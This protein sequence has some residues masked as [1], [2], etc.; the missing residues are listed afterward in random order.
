MAAPPGG[1]RDEGRPRGRGHHP[2]HRREGAAVPRRP[3]LPGAGR[4]RRASTAP[5]RA[6]RCRCA[7]WPRSGRSTSCWRSAC[8]RAA[9]APTAWR[10]GRRVYELCRVRLFSVGPPGARYQDV[11]LDLR[12]V[13]DAGAAAARGRPT[14]SPPDDLERRAAPAGTGVGAVPGERRRQ[15]GAAQAGVLGAAAGPPP[16]RGHDEHRRA[17]E[18]RARRG[19]RARRVRVDAHRHRGGCSSPAR[20]PSGRATSCPPT[21][22]RLA[23][24]WYSF[25]PGPGF[26][27]D[28]LPFTADGRRVTMAAFKD[29]LHRGSAGQAPAAGAGLGDRA[30]RVDAPPRRRRPRPGAVPLPARDERRGGRGGRGVLVRQ[31]RGVRRLPPARGA[32]PGGA[33]GAR[34]PRGGLRGAR[35][36]QRADLATRNATSSRARSSGWSRCRTRSGRPAAHAAAEDGRPTGRRRAGRGDRRRGKAEEDGA[37]LRPRAR[38]LGARAEAVAA[39]DGTAAAG[40]HGGAAAAGRGADASPRRS[41]AETAATDAH[42]AAQARVAAWQAVE[43]V[44]AHQ[45]ATARGAAA[46]RVVDAEQERARPALRAR[47][48][49][50]AALAAGLR[51][52]I[53]DAE[54]AADGS[55]GG[56]RR[57]GGTRRRRARPGAAAGEGGRGHAAAADAARAALREI[58]ERVAAADLP[59][60]AA[61]RCRAPGTPHGAAQGRRADAGRPGRRL[62]GVVEHVAA[63]AARPSATPRTRPRRSTAAAEELSALRR[64][65]QAADAERLRRTARRRRGQHGRGAG[66]GRAPGGRRRPRRARRRAAPGR[67][68]RRRGDRAGH[69][70]RRPWSSA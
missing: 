34:R 54:A 7:S 39:Q 10:R 36:P 26:G 64:A 24:A 57:R 38:R 48:A 32:R 25:R 15:V 49:A 67:A 51:A 65:R 16:G 29:R 5:R 20:C 42:D 23:D 28:D 41:A 11:C 14:C 58:R 52:T 21:R 69:R 17:G 70:R 40:D 2:R 18:V 66:R 3:G 59:P 62:G 9:R 8:S 1:H 33:A 30:P 43:P 50:A 60:C 45:L 27:L 44:L 47:Q 4:A 68:A 22:Q 61:T 63:A 6:T 56:G 46:A 37:S 31:R 55:R 35:S 12:G 19:R 13:G 53:V